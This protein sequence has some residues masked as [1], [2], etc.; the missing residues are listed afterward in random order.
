MGVL[1]LVEMKKLLAQLHLEREQWHLERQSLVLRI[2]QLEVE[3]QRLKA[4]LGLT[5]SNSS[6]SPSSDKSH[7]DRSL[8]AKT[9]RRPGGQRGHEG[10]KLQF[11]KNPDLI[12]IHSPTRCSD[13]GGD[14]N[15][16]AVE[17]VESR[18]VYELPA[19]K[20]EVTEH[21][22][23]FKRCPCCRK[24]NEGVFPQ[25]VS[26]QTQYGS[27]LKALGVYLLQSQFIP[28]QRTQQ[29]FEDLLG[30]R[31]S[32]GTLCQANKEAAAALLP[33]QEAVKERLLLEQVVHFDESSMFV[34]KERHWVHSASTSKL[35]YYSIHPKRGTEAM[36]QADILPR[37]KNTALHD[38]W[39]SYNHYDC[40]HAFC[41]AHHL[42]ELKSAYEQ[43][44]MAWAQ[45]MIELLCAIKKTVDQAK[46]E[47]LNSLSLTMLDEFQQQYELITQRALEDY[48]KPLPSSKRGKP[49]QAK[50]KNLLDRLILYQDQT[51]TFMRNFQIPFDNNQAE[52]DIRMVKLKQK[53]SGTFRSP[54][55]ARDFSINRGAISTARK[56][57]RSILRFIQ[58]AFMGLLR[59][60]LS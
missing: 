46:G 55:G 60:A 23:E 3:N 54:D 35:T 29:L 38:H 47:G 20:V 11:S 17:H 44:K 36:D 21:R 41:N 16:V 24:R 59:P 40:E 43:E 42:R 56:Q 51:L 9:G 15:Q 49:K 8:R 13:C 22:V 57:G 53:V 26:A 25:G 30:H 6:Q 48:P 27:H 10:D 19:L 33:F 14:L 18:Q 28:Y 34:Q 2:E 39:E 7:K 52:R 31:L 58:D 12:E 1:M 45:E 32:T 37:F 50:S 5:S 4:R